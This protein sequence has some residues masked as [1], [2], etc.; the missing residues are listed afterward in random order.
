MGLKGNAPL[1]VALVF[2]IVCMSLLTRPSASETSP[3]DL[4]VQYAPAGNST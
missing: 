2:S 3:L 1:H 4:L